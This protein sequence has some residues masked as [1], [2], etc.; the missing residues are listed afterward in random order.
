MCMVP[1]DR[2]L[3]ANINGK[4][5]GTGIPDCLLSVLI[6]IDI[7]VQYSFLVCVCVCVCV[8]LNH[9]LTHV[10][11]YS[12]FRRFGSTL[13]VLEGDLFSNDKIMLYFTK[14]KDCNKIKQRESNPIVR[15]RCF[16]CFVLSYIINLQDECICFLLC[17]N[18]ELKA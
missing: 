13:R 11:A 5:E 1:F 6:R 8:D 4:R 17:L 7:V 14:K 2:R 18:F 9:A 15:F 12:N 3:T 10:L 16:V